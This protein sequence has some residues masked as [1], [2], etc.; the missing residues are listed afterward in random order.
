V[1]RIALVGAS[2]SMG[3]GVE[4][5]EGF[6]QILEGMLNE[7][8]PSKGGYERYEIINLSVP[9]YHLL[10]RVY[11]ARHVAPRFNPHIMIMETSMRDMRRTMYESLP[12]RIQQERD[13]G[14]D[15]IRDIVR[16]SAVRPSDSTLRIE[17]R[18]QRFVNELVIGAFE[19]LARTQ[20]VTGTPIVP[21]VMRLE[22][23]PVHR[24]LLQLASI[25]E[26]AGL[27][28]L[29]IFDAY[30]GQ[31]WDEMHFSQTDFHPTAKGHARLADDI[32]EKMLQ[33]PQVRPLLLG[34]GRR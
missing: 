16:R 20:R 26:N 11:V 29:R 7:V 31:V 1:F 10:E 2:N 21:M 4:F 24:S 9:R 14:F 23:D 25:S 34:E 12:R 17:Q 33:H 15:F 5:H 13:L 8:L 19:E 6:E 28:T 22:V 30:E 18:L 32:F 27:A 3:Q